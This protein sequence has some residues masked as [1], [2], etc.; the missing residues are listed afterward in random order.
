MIAGPSGSCR[1]TFGAR[2]FSALLRRYPAEFRA[3]F[4]EEMLLLYERIWSPGSC[5]IVARRAL[6]FLCASVGA[7]SRARPRLDPLG[8]PGSRWSMPKASDNVHSV[9]SGER[10]RIPCAVR[11]AAR[12]GA[13]EASAQRLWRK[14]SLR[15]GSTQGRASWR[16][17]RSW[18]IPASRKREITLQSSRARAVFRAA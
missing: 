15:G 3:Q 2:L 8:R 5:R 11:P 12:I 1:G 7:S 16:D 13:A 10:T 6:P 9:Y 14:G 4:G 17:D 18:Y